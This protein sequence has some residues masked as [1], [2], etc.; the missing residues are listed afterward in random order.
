MVLWYDAITLMRV[1]GLDVGDRHIGIALS[2]ALGLTAQRLTLLTRR[3]QLE[4]VE[5]IAALAAQHGASAIVVGLPLMMSGKAG[6]QVTK[7]RAFAAA[8]ERRV[9]VPIQWMDERLTTVQ[10]TRALLELNTSRR[11]RKHMIDQVAAQLILQQ[12]LDQARRPE[13]PA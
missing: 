9:G 3:T 13:S 5:T 8:L 11:K 2:D 12:F 10:G 4:D 1:L 7:V 6:V